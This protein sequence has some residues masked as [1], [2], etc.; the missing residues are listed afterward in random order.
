MHHRGGPRVKQLHAKAPGRWSTKCSASI[1][2]E[3]SRYWK[4]SALTTFLGD[5]ILPVSVEGSD[6]SSRT[7]PRTAF[8]S[9]IPAPPFATT[10]VLRRHQLVELVHVLNTTLWPESTTE[11]RTSLSLR[12][13]LRM[14]SSPLGRPVRAGSVVRTLSETLIC[15]KVL[16]AA[17]TSSVIFRAASEAPSTSRPASACLPTSEIESADRKTSGFDTSVSKLTT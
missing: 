15:E 14:M 11:L 16:L 8:T 4:Q 9:M 3:R 1:R 10:A 6:G 7:S 2:T 13:P 12:V 5:E 17:G